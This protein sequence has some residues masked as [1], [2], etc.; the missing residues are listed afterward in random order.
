MLTLACHPCWW[1]RDTT[2]SEYLEACHNLLY[3]N[4]KVEVNEKFTSKGSITSPVGRRIPPRLEPWDDF[5]EEQ[6]TIFGT[7][8]SKFPAHTAAFRSQHYLRTRGKV[9]AARSIGDEEALKLVYQDL[10]TEPVTL[11]SQRLQDKDSIRAE[12]DIGAGIAFETRLNA[13]GEA[14]RESTERPRTPD[15]MANR[16]RPDQICAYRRDGADPDQ[17]T[18]AFIIE[19]KAPHKLTMPHLRSGLRAMNIFEEV[20]NRPTSPPQEDKEALF[21]YHADRLVAAA[22]TQTFDYMSQA[23]LTYGCLTTGQGFVFLK[24]DWTDPITLLYH[25]AEPGPEVD[26]HRENFLCCTA[27]SQMLAFTI[28]ALDSGAT[29]ERGQDKR[30]RA[31]KKLKTWNVDWELILRSIPPTERTAPPTSPAYQPRTYKG[32]DRSP[33]LLRPARSRAAGRP[34]CR[35]GPAERDRSPEFDEEGSEPRMPD[36]PS[37]VQPRNAQRAPARRPRGNNGN[38]GSSSSGSRSSNRRYCTQNC[39]RGLVAGMFLTRN[40]R[41]PLDHASWLGLLREQLRRTLDDGVVPLRKQGARGVL[42][43]VTLLAYGYTFVSKATTAR[44]VPELEHE[45]QVYERL[46]PLQG[47]RVPVFLGAVDLRQVGRRYYYDID[48]QLVYMMFVSWGGCSLD[49]VEVSD[50]AKLEREVMRAVR[51]LHPHGVAHTDMRD[52]NILWNAETERAMV[53]DFEQAVLAEPPRRGL[54]PIVPNKRALRANV[55]TKTAVAGPKS[56]QD[57]ILLKMQQE[58]ILGAKYAL[59]WPRK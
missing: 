32:V 58:D 57:A 37:P 27:V 13:L 39:L 35:P 54:G 50:M 4:F 29:G 12:F 21:Q 40:R 14:N 1:V 22:L 9:I 43:Q 51:A 36:T 47:D 31:I 45:A 41:H 11:I 48:V 30:Q 19:Q 26:E 7:L 33:Y 23:G 3:A 55:D 17:R 2:L 6:R 52:A 24:I 38:A 56:K 34:R 44:F 15:G 53:I 20:V 5:L 8:L 42:F 18:M 59:Y 49:E 28:L 46:R 10:V 25:L 16:F